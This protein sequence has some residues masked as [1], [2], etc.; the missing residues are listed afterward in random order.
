MLLPGASLPQ[1]PCLAQGQR[2]SHQEALVAGSISSPRAVRVTAKPLILHT[3]I[4]MGE[5]KSPKKEEK[6]RAGTPRGG[7][8]WGADGSWPQ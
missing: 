6:L 1:F 8:H 3:H 2:H 7:G 4:L 5:N